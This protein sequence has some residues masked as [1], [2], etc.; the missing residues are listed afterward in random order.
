MKRIILVAL[1]LGLLIGSW[2][3]SVYA[4]E[5]PGDVRQRTGELIRND[6]WVA[7]RAGVP[8]YTTVYATRLDSTQL[9]IIGKFFQVP[10]NTIKKFRWGPSIAPPDHPEAGAVTYTI[11]YGK[12]SKRTVKIAPSG[13]T[14]EP[15]S[16]P[17]I[18][19]GARVRLRGADSPIKLAP[20]SA[21]I[22]STS[23]Q[24]RDHVRIKAPS[25]QPGIWIIGTVVSLKADT[26]RVKH[27]H[28]NPPLAIPLAA[29]TRLEVSRNRYKENATIGFLIG[30]TFGSLLGLKAVSVPWG[31]NREVRSPIVGGLIIGIPSAL[32]GAA[33][34]TL[35]DDRWEPVLL[36]L[37]KGFSPYSGVRVALRFE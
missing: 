20:K 27:T 32:L 29:V 26:V 4:Q 18:P 31:G 3:S 30:G 10:P 9:S 16:T 14:I 24:R 22:L 19:S 33:I 12:N 15:S 23:I 36:P 11:W 21:P 34:G 7:M 13:A 5:K 8:S 35:G 2:V 28:G 6:D 37:S 17:S 1:V 25:Y